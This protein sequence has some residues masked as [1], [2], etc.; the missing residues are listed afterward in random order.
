MADYFLTIWGAILSEKKY[1]QH[2]KIEHYELNPVWQKHIAQKQWVNPKFLLIT[3]AI[4]LFCFFW[5]FCWSDGDF[6]SEGLFGYFVILWANIIG[7]HLSNI[8]TFV[9]MERHPESI[10][11]EISMDHV[12][13]LKMAQFRSLGLVVVL[14]SI[15]IFSPTPFVIGGLCSAVV[16]MITESRWIAKARSK[17]KKMEMPKV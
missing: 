14:T 10:T 9:Y 5:S 4:F 2:F 13:M 3:A 7:R 16:L 12:L 1:R 17:K 15:V 11:G 8:L 6:V